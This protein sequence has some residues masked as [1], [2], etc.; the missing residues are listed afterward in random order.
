MFRVARPAAS[1]RTRR[2]SAAAA[3]PLGIARRGWTGRRGIEREVPAG[4]RHGPRPEPLSCHRGWVVLIAIPVCVIDAGP[5]QPC[6]R[7]GP[8]PGSGRPARSG[9]C[10]SPS[11][12][13]QRNTAGPRFQGISGR[14]AHPGRWSGHGWRSSAS[15]PG[16]LR[17]QGGNL[18]TG[19]ISRRPSPR[20]ASSIPGPSNQRTMGLY[21][22]CSI[23]C[24]AGPKA[25]LRRDPHRGRDLRKAR[26]DR[27]PRRDRRTAETSVE[28]L[29]TGERVLH[30]LP[31]PAQRLSRRDPLLQIGSAEQR[32]ARCVRP[33][34]PSR[35]HRDAGRS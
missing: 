32:P 27:S 25:P 22:I 12:Y 4:R 15:R 30:H 1:A 3:R 2:A 11:A 16:A 34:P 35:R 6:G 21:S 17:P 24:R 8:R 23:N 19:Q 33:A 14:V 31:D 9:R 10:G 26:P 29:E 18:S 13:A 7:R 5:A 20:T 28:R